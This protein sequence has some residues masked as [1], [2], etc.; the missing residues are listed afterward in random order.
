MP[1]FSFLLL[2][3]PLH[4]VHYIMFILDQFQTTFDSVL[5]ILDAFRP[6]VNISKDEQVVAL[7]KIGK[8]SNVSM[9]LKA[10]RK[11]Y[12]Y[13]LSPILMKLMV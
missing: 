4:N 10:R 12:K 6:D 11:L 7:E 8:V 9:I 1:Y 3:N 13:Y 2:Q 5:A